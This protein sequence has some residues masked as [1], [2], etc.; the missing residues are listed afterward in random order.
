MNSEPIIPVNSWLRD[1][2]AAWNRFWFTPTNP[3]TVCL[4]RILA[5]GMLFYTHLVWTLELPTFFSNDGVFSP[6]YRDLYNAGSSF[7]WSHFDWFNSPAWMWGS[8]IVA[9]IVLAAFTIG[10]WT[11]VTSILAFLIVVSYCNRAGG[12]LFGL[13]QINGFLALYLA[14]APCGLMYS[15]DAWLARRKSDADAAS[16]IT[17]KSSLA[18]VAIRLMQLHLCVVYFFA[19]VGKLQGVTWWDGTAIWGALASY[20]YQTMDVTFLVHVP[21]FINIL[22]LTSVFWEVSYPFMIWPKLTRPIWLFMAVP[23]HVGIGMC[24]GMITF[25]VI[26]LIANVAF[27]SPQLVER[28]IS[29]PM[30]KLRGDRTAA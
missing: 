21:W 19:G 30:Q 17:P 8:H 9:L 4:I 16:L 27:V 20:E 3:A 25:G 13:D 14:I 6:E 11:R 22:T 26:M 23:L 2:L 10:L 28:L 29:W 5:G 18:N 15:V 1:L 12:A 7:V 24:M